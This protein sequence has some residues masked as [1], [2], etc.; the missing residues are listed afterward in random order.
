MAH[1]L[2][3]KRKGRN[4][5]QTGESGKI[6]AYRTAKLAPLKT[7]GGVSPAVT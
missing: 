7:C 6:T 4:K 5:E 1:S 2:L 3:V